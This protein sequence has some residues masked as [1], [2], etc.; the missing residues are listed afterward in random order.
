MQTCRGSHTHSLVDRPRR[1]GQRLH[2]RL[3]H[4]R[5]PA[6][7][8]RSPG[9]TT[10]RR[11]VR[12]RRGGASR[13]SR[14]R[15]PSPERGRSST[16]P[17]CSPTRRPGRSTACRTP[18]DADAPVRQPLG[19]VADHR[20]LPRHHGLPGLGLA[21]GAC[22]G[23][24]ILIDISDPA[25]PR[26]HRRGGRPELRVLALGHVQQR[27]HEGHVHRR[28]GRR[29]RGALPGDRPSRVGR[30]RDLRHR[31]RQDAFPS[32]YK[33]PC[34]R[35][36]RK[37]VSAHNGSLVPVPGRDIMAQAWYQGGISLM[38]FT[39]AATR[40]KSP[41][42]TAARSARRLSSRRVLVGLLVQRPDLRQRA[43][44]RVRRVRASAEREISAAEIAAA[45][46]VGWPS[47]TRSISRR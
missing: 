17:G 27:R 13:S 8:R 36:C 1:S 26:R 35:R 19:A 37:T 28:V 40:G 22:E 2:L 46:E 32:Y 38:D 24:G 5:R 10:T 23:N 29:H 3:R 4:R 31:R 47:S 41:S 11:P 33:L 45:R 25:N 39:D 43:R 34:R 20:R 7:D 42:S 12:T 14:C 21:A 18:A 15:S 9:A 44:S 30:Q 16:S 6:R